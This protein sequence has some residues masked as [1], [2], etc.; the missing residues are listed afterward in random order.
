[1][2]SGKRTNTS[3]NSK[4]ELPP[5][6]PHGKLNI[7][8]NT[9][10]AKNK[11]QFA[12]EGENE[13]NSHTQKQFNNR[14]CDDY[15]RGAPTDRLIFGYAPS[16]PTE[17]VA[18]HSQYTP[19]QWKLERRLRYRNKCLRSR[20]AYFQEV[21]NLASGHLKKSKVLH[22]EPETSAIK[23]RLY[24]IEKIEEEKKMLA[25][26]GDSSNDASNNNNNN[27]QSSNNTS[28][29]Q[30]VGGNASKNTSNNASNK[31]NNSSNNNKNKD[32][33]FGQLLSDMFGG[34]YT[35]ST[36]NNTNNKNAKES[37]KRRQRDE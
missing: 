10:T 3:T 29:Q 5:V 24:W 12:A 22:F 36:S 27:N 26:G 18:F 2:S 4:V 1:M 32:G 9:L 37:G 14:P 20:A 15:G 8:L 23:L 17:A 33:N 21:A 35:A 7:D 19:K 11:N 13:Q 25:G 16:V 6:N 30:Q 34:G 28:N 31:G